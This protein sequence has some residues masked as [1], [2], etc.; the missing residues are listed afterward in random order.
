VADVEMRCEAF[1]QARRF[2]RVADQVELPDPAMA[3]R[4]A[5]IHELHRQAVYAQIAEGQCIRLH[6]RIGQALEAAYG[7]RHTEI[8]PQLAIHFERG[9]D[10]A[11]ALRYL[12]AAAE[13][14]RLRFADREAMGYLEAALALLARLP[15]DDE[16][17]RRELALRLS[18]G[19]ILV[20]LC[21]FASEQVRENLERAA[22]L[23]AAVGSLPQRFAV[24]YA[25]W[26]VHAIRAER[27]AAI[28]G[29]AALEDLARREGTPEQ[30]VVAASV[31]V[32]TAT[33]DGRFA[34]ATRLMQRRLARP[35][36]STGAAAP[37]LGPEPRLVA[38]T[39]SALALWF[40]GH[41]ER[42]RSTARTVVSRARKLGH[43]VT[44]SAVLMQAALLDL[45]C[46]NAAAGGALADELVSLSAEHGFALW[47]AAGS[48]LSGWAS[49]QQGHAPQA[50]TPGDNR[51]SKGER[52]CSANSSSQPSPR[53]RLQ[54]AS[55]WPPAARSIGR[56]RSPAASRS[57][58]SPS[59]ERR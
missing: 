42:A 13:R 39:H 53:W 16:R 41:P 4:Y 23:S 6:L 26:Y 37:P 49:V 17:R 9:R 11:R 19:A 57:P 56:R 10:D 20:D 40:L 22:E 59:A 32:R 51:T 30:R 55:S 36:Y 28:A 54:P 31:L 58:A 15:E 24:S 18:L 29:A 45:L 8:A 7:T 44:L 25:R 2:L 33:Y 12:T 5:F 1:A 43:F 35:Y 27:D 3:R 46:R 52:T 47:H 50:R 21:G 38:G 14:A 34:E 48:M